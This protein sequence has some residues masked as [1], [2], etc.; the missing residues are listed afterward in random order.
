MRRLTHDQFVKKVN[1]DKI[2]FL[3]NF[4]NTRTKILSQCLICG[5]KWAANPRWLYKGCGCPECGKKKAA[6]TPKWTKA[7]K[8]F[9]GKLKALRG[10]KFTLLSEYITGTKSI[11]VKCNDCGTIFSTKPIRLL[12]KK[13]CGCIKCGRIKKGIGSRLSHV[14]FL[15]RINL[16]NSNIDILGKY[17]TSEN[18]IKV[19]CKKCN[20]VWNP[21]AGRLYKRGCQNCQ[22]SKA[23]NKIEEILIQNNIEF[24]H[25][26][27]F[28]DFKNNRGQKYRFDFGILKNGKLIYL[29]EYDGL[30]HFQEVRA[31][32]GKNRLERQKQVDELKDIYCKNNKIK[33]IRLDYKIKPEKITIDMLR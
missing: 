2:I 11:K 28:E 24:K 18:R 27:T 14:D 12:N 29:I 23:E 20:L 6:N 31:W 3:E 32:G 19:R 21:V 13:Y 25:Q 9:S 26:Y 10:D 8:E 33:L 30:Q 17:T 22:S 7:P 1:S 4:V 15:K 16:I 5:Y